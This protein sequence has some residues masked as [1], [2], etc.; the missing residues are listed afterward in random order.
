MPKISRLE[1]LPAPERLE[2]PGAETHVWRADLD[3]RRWPG[4]DG[5]PGDERARAARIVRPPSR[6]RWIASRWA[7]RGVLGRY[8]GR[9]AAGLALELGEHG[10]PRLADPAS[11]LA[12]NLSHSGGVALIAV[13]ADREVGVDVER[14][15]AKRPRAFYERWAEREA[16]LKCI[17][18]GL[19][20]P[21]PPEA[22]A[23]IVQRLEVGPG[24]AATLATSGPA[25]LRCW[26]IGP[27]LRRGVIGV[28]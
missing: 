16:R 12:F 9:P 1:F 8:L 10:K 15:A 6:R 13:A 23:L 11:G 24:H 17:G 26:T 22:A 19:T 20:E 3:E 18:T 14:V 28:S 5:L 25:G 4:A 27:P 7:L 21:M 2:I